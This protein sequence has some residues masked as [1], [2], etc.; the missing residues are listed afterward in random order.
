MEKLRSKDIMRGIVLSFGV[1]TISHLT[2]LKASAD[3]WYKEGETVYAP[4]QNREIPYIPYSKDEVAQIIVEESI[5]I[6]D[7]TNKAL[8]IAWC[9]S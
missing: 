9:E 1:L 8:R 3:P 5:N 2:A 7:D 4:N 6:G